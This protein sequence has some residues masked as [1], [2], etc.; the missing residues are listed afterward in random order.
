MTRLAWWWQGFK[1]R[2]IAAPDPSQ[3]FATRPESRRVIW[4]P[5]SRPDCQ[6]LRRQYEGGWLIVAQNDAAAIE[7]LLAFSPARGIH[8]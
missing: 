3:V 6:L 7:V 2:H 8:T 4:S 1:R 5:I